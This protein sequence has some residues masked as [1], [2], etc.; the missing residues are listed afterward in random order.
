MTPQRDTTP[1]TILG[2]DP[3]T[4]IMGYGLLRT[5]HTKAEL[6]DL[7][8][9]DLRKMEDPYHKL[10]CILQQLT[11]LLQA[12]HPDVMAI[13]APF[14]GKNIQS[15]IKLARAQGVAI[16]AAMQQGVAIAEYAPMK[17][18]MAITGNG[19]ASKQQVADML[20]RILHIPQQLTP[21]PDATDALAAAYCHHL[22]L[23]SPYHNT[24]SHTTWADF[25]AHNPHRIK[26]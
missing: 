12:H 21:L 1:R 23:M 17:I 14:C 18:K 6:L 16:A 9:I 11:L 25:I 5:L 20:R 13:E 26:R 7:G 22:Q 8:V 15:T 2:I 24:A 4:N 19:Q 10:G 3:G